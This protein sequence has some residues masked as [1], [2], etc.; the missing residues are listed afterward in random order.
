MNSTVIT[1][2]RNPEIGLPTAFPLMKQ[3]IIEKVYHSSV[4]M[5]FLRQEGNVSVG[6]HIIHRFLGYAEE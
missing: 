4:Y 1:N 6:E 5:E 3:D 2:E